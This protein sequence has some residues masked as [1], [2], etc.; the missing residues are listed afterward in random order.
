[1]TGLILTTLPAHAALITYTDPLSFAAA[2][3]LTTIGFEGLGVAPN[4]SITYNNST[5]LVIS[6]VQFI[7]ERTASTYALAVVN[8]GNN[9]T[10]YDFGSGAGL[11]GPDYNVSPGFVP[12]IHIILPSSVTAFG[13]DLMT[14][15][16]NALTYQA[17]VLGTN[18][19]VTTANRPT[20]TFFGVTSDTPISSV[21]LTLTGTIQANGS[22]AL[23]DNVQFGSADPPPVAEGCTLL[24]IGSGL[25]LLGFFRKRLQSQ[26][27]A[28]A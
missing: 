1:L 8:P 9:T 6:G 27:P 15:S 13:V 5:G 23:I 14:L 12:L 22:Q 28:A 4:G 3:N 2:A 20:R 10:Y 26:A 7:G 11:K 17:T 24:L 16:P 18:I 25:G 19:S 21:D